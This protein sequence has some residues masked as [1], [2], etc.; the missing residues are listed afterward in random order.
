MLA[1]TGKDLDYPTR[2]V[3]NRFI[4]G[5]YLS[6]DNAETLAEAKELTH[7]LQAAANQT[8][9]DLPLIF[10]TDQEGA[11]G[12]L[13]PET[14]TG[15]G[16]LALGSAN[17][18]RLTTEIYGIYAR[19][20]MAAGYNV[21]LSPCAD[22]NS[23]PDNPIIGTRAFG[24][25]VELVSRHVQAAVKGALQNR[26]AC[27]GK[28]FPGHGDT[29]LDSHRTLPVV[30]RSLEHLLEQDLAPFQ[31]A[32]DSGVPMMMTSH[33]IFPQIDPDNPATLSHK[34]MTGLLRDR[35]GFDG[36]I[37]TDSM[38]MWGMRKNY[39]PAEAAVQAL[40]AGCDIIML[41]EEHYEN[42][43]G[44]Y[45]AKQ[46]ATIDGVIAAVKEGRLALERVEQSLARIYTFK[47]KLHKNISDFVQLSP[48]VSTTEHQNTAALAAEKAIKVLR[49]DQSLLPLQGKLILAGISSDDASNMV[50]ATRG[51]GPNEPR[52]AFDVFREV[53][54]KLHPDAEVLSPEQLA[55]LCMGEETIPVDVTLVAV[56]EDYPLPGLDYDT[57]AQKDLIQ[58]LVK[59]TAGRLVVMALRSDYELRHFDGLS[60]YVCAYSSRACSAKALAEFNVE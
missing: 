30:D 34:I 9:I 13:V 27:C 4:N 46:A 31:A 18:P 21:I 29:G 42:S 56:T 19:E 26:I 1:F 14:V 41:S 33:I 23:N 5:F 50:A 35:M 59:I 22:I 24:D 12:V 32:I 8:G 39:S 60:T 10:A 58:Q 17:D 36:V 53:F 45:E 38:N 16:N 54:C 6:Q 43:L 28:H 25:S 52:P 55:R 37:V 2:L 57:E 7:R 3:K 15:P 47:L 48:R 51:I 11:W 20:I 44:D 40:I 49:D